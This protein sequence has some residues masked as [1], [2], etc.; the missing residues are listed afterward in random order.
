MTKTKRKPT[1]KSLDAKLRSLVE[2]YMALGYNWQTIE[3]SLT[4]G[5][6]ANYN[7]LWL[8]KTK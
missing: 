8:K 2:D 7:S 4:I 6:N 1:V 3:A 5:G